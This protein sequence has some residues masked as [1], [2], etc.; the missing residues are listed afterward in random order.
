MKNKKTL[1]TYFKYLI[2]VL[3][4]LINTIPISAA[5]NPKDLKLSFKIIEG[6]LNATIS[7]EDGG[8]MINTQNPTLNEEAY[9]YIYQNEKDNWADFHILSIQIE[10]K[11]SS[12]QKIDLHIES[13]PQHKFKLKEDS[14]ALI[15]KTDTKMF[16]LSKKLQGGIEIPPGFKGKIY[17]KFDDFISEDKEELLEERMLSN[18]SGWG[19]TLIPSSEK[20]NS[21]IINEVTLLSKEETKAFE[22]LQNIKIVGD[23]KVQIPVLGEGISPYSL[24]GQSEDLKIKFYLKEK[25][26][27]VSISEQGVLKV[28]DKAMPGE[29]VLYIHVGE[30][31][32][33]EKTVLLVESWTV[34]K[35]DENGVPY[36][37]VEPSISPTVQSMEKILFMENSVPYVQIFFALICLGY[38]ALY[39]Y[40]RR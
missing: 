22:D 21:I 15:Q 1:S 31:L 23:E 18:I 5:A 6:N 11:S 35:K 12:Y 10:N 16:V 17:A 39:L 38:F 24:Q 32:K 13:S 34:N 33:L 36:G 7:E 2:L 37:L 20:D 14:V 3:L 19:I 25:Y 40:W 8:I 9:L 26:K 4:F 29:I 30:Q 27:D 28:K